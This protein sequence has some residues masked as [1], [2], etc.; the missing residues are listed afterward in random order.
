ML[1]DSEDDNKYAI[2]NI[3]ES[4]KE[5]NLKKMNEIIN[6]SNIEVIKNN[7]KINPNEIYDNENINESTK[8]LLE[9]IIDSINI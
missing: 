4:T 5:E 7:E 1:P 3:I 9:K 2:E 6:K 8:E